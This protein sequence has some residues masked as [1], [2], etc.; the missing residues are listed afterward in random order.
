[1]LWCEDGKESLY[2]YGQIDVY[3][4]QVPEG[5]PSDGDGS[6]TDQE[7]LSS[8]QNVYRALSEISDRS[9]DSS[10]FDDARAVA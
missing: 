5:I 2:F 6:E 8:V 1:M 10:E 4:R 7:C 3:K 9:S